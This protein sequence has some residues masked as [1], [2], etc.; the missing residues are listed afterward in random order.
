F[1]GLE[2]KVTISVGI[3]KSQPNDALSI[4][5]LIEK[6]DDALYNAKDAGRN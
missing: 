2:I 4:E 6:A 5:S 1:S 3:S